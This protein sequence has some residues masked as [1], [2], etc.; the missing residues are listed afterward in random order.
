[1]L[2]LI[3][4]G[5]LEETRIPRHDGDHELMLAAASE[6][7]NAFE[8]VRE[9]R[10]AEGAEFDL[11][12]DPAGTGLVGPRSSPLTSMEGELEAKLT[13]LNPN[14]AAVMVQY[15][16]QIGLQQGDPVAVSIS[17]SLPGMNLCL[18]AALNVMQLDPVI[19]TSVSASAWGASDPNFS[20]LDV[21]SLLQEKGIFPFRSD[22]A[23]LGGSNDMGR[24][25]SPE[26][27]R[28]GMEAIERNG[29]ALLASENLEDAIARRDAFFTEPTPGGRSKAYVSVGGEVV[30]LGNRLY[31]DFL[32]A[33]VLYEPSLTEFSPKGNMILMLERG[34]PAVDFRNIQD[35]AREVGLPVA[36][37]YLPE[38]GE[39]QFFAKTS[40][41]FSLA[42]LFLLAYC[43]V[44]VLVLAPEVHRGLFDRWSGKPNGGSV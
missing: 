29:L 20:W 13:A 26:G 21:E 42:V 4:Q 35:L 1:V 9:Q 6:A 19:I 2:A 12:N 11:V 5:I 43:A 39:G 40:Y 15:L 10:L 24:G 22:A 25:I 41:N 37:D 3:L 36:P 38:P 33:G 31:E 8:A 23:T 16:R 27:R 14:W 34:V 7:A 44:C 32:P 18:L 17:G 28:L 30:N